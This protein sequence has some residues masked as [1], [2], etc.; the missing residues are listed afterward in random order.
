MF[1]FSREVLHDFA[2]NSKR[3]RV[4]R[5]DRL[6]KFIGAA[7]LRR[8]ESNRFCT[9]RGD[10][11]EKHTHAISNHSTRRDFHVYDVC[12]RARSREMTRFAP[13]LILV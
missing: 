1:S 13:R 8:G 10:T 9:T 6:M 11:F 3:A 5:N 12:A 4:C 2:D 7:A